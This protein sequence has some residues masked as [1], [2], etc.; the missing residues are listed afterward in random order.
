[1]R[2]IRFVCATTSNG[3]AETFRNFETAATVTADVAIWQAAMATLSVP[4][5]FDPVK[6]G[7][8]S[9]VSDALSNS[10]PVAKVIWEARR[11]WPGAED[12]CLVSLGFFP[13]IVEASG[14]RKMAFM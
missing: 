7:S 12:G 5:F 8:T 10:N 11:L 4:I 1:M 2:I 3:I 6:I 14:A 13:R 9:Y